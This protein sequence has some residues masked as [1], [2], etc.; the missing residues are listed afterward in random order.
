[1]RTVRAKMAQ[2]YP[3]KVWQWMGVVFGMT[4]LWAGGI[5]GVK[6]YATDRADHNAYSVDLQD[7]DDCMDEVRAHNILTAIVNAVEAATGGQ[8][9]E[10]VQRLID[11]LQ[12]TIEHDYPRSDSKECGPRPEAPS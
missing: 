7:W 9:S 1:M 5:W 4:A 8:A 2:T 11:D 3:V 12:S 10:G 6:L